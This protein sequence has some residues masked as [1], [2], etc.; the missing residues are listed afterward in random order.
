M[1]FQNPWFS[2]VEIAIVATADF[3]TI[4]VAVAIHKIFC[5]FFLIF[6][7]CNNINCSKRSRRNSFFI[8]S[9]K[10][11]SSKISNSIWNGIKSEFHERTTIYYNALLIMTLLSLFLRAI[12]IC[13]LNVASGRVCVC[14]CI[15]ALGQSV[16]KLYEKL[17]IY[18]IGKLF[19]MLNS[20]DPY[21]VRVC[22]AYIHNVS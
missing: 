22:T 16:E 2:C 5:T 7:C 21:C 1:G 9:N 15:Q 18:Y 8:K 11:H 14:V 19:V 4:I 13:I 20:I 17:F 6:L 10:I 12:C 3:V